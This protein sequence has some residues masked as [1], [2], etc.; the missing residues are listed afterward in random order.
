MLAEKKKETRI[1]GLNDERRDS[2]YGSWR[3]EE[4]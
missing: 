3:A 2:C 4:G 1:G